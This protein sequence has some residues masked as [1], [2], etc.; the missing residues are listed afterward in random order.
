MEDYILNILQSLRESSDLVL[1]AVL[2]LS[3]VIENLF[4]PI[5]GDTITVFGAF[6]V[7]T[8]RLNYLLVYLST[9]LG[10]VI[11]FTL[12]FQIGRA[13]GKEFFLRGKYRIF[14]SQNIL[15][16]ER[17]FA[18]FGYLA[19]LANRFLPGIRSAISLVAGLSMLSTIRIFF[20]ALISS[21]LWNLIWIHM[22]YTLGTN[23]ITVRRAMKKILY[24]YNVAAFTILLAGLALF[25]LY[26][27]MRRRRD[28]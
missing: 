17:W 9:T 21:S 27:L 14:S 13:L 24:Q 4:P 5:P 3:A 28:A 26:R 10:S 15:E 16:A 19:V 25:L 20:Y 23:W 6:L 18:R 11:G 7:G 1:Y 8:G 22:G 2:F 12:L